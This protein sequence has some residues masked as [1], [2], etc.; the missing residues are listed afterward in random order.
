[1]TDF[2]MILLW[3]VSVLIIGAVLMQPAKNNDAMS[4]FTGGASD[5][6]SESKS[7]GFESFI[8]RVTIILGFLFFAI[9]LVLMWIS[10]H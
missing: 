3:I 10:Q 1:M 2:L 7:R 6:F 5:L 4:S 9:A 8:Q